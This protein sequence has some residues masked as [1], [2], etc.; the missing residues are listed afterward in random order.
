MGLAF[1][2]PA[3]EFNYRI[4]YLSGSENL[5]SFPFPVRPIEMDD[6]DLELTPGGKLIEA[7]DTLNFRK[8]VLVEKSTVSGRVNIFFRLPLKGVYYFTLYSTV[9]Q[10]GAFYEGAENPSSWTH[11]MR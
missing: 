4:Q 10:I 6:A 8:H 11:K 1:W 2:N 3:C 5:E 7:T 9:P